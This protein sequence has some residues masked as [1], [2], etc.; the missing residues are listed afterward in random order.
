MLNGK[1][2]VAWGSQRS[3]EDEESGAVLTFGLA[4]EAGPDKERSVDENGFA[5]YSYLAAS[6][7]KKLLKAARR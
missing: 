4:K 1:Y 5:A 3:S 2:T 6:E 7:K